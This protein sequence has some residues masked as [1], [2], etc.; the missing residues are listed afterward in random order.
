MFT[1]GFDWIL[2]VQ[3]YNGVYSFPKGKLEEGDTQ[4]SCAIREIKEETD[5]E[6]LEESIDEGEY[7]MVTDWTVVQKLFIVK[8]VPEDFKF[9]PNS[10]GEIKTIDWFSIDELIYKVSFSDRK[11][12]LYIQPFL[13]MIC[14]LVSEYSRPFP[15]TTWREL[16]LW[17]ELD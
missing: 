3:S 1:K 4:I 7:L 13:Y 15:I 6:I 16:Y 17:K 10:M 5:Y 11:K 14:Q 9:W 8:N 2:I 12:F